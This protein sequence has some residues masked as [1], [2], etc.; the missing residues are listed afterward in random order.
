MG[1]WFSLAFYN[2]SRKYMNGLSHFILDCI[3][4]ELRGSP[5]YATRAQFK[6]RVGKYTFK[7]IIFKRKSEFDKWVY[8]N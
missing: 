8:I 4:V 5:T 6:I 2:I 1:I 7:T 3:R